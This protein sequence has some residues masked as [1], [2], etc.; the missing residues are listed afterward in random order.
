VKIKKKSA[1]G[2][3][4]NKPK[5]KSKSILGIIGNAGKRRK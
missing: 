3:I 2:M 5:I 4:T 1:L